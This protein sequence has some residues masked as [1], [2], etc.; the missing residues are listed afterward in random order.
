MTRQQIRHL[1]DLISSPRQRITSTSVF[2]LLAAV[3]ATLISLLFAFE[4]SELREDK[5]ASLQ[6]QIAERATSLE[7]TLAE[8]IDY[9]ARLNNELSYRLQHSP[10]T[11]DKIGFE[12]SPQDSVWSLRIADE[13]GWPVLLASKNDP[14]K[15]DAQASRELTALA[16]M[17]STLPL[18]DTGTGDFVWTYYISLHSFLLMYPVHDLTRLKD[19]VGIASLH[20][21]FAP[22]GFATRIVD[23]ALLD[24]V[25]ASTSAF[26]S[27]AYSDRAGRGLMTTV[28]QRLVG[29][30]GFRGVLCVDLPLDQLSPFTNWSDTGQL[31]LVNQRDQ[32]LGRNGDLAFVNEQPRMLEEILPHHGRLPSGTSEGNPPVIQLDDEGHIRITAPIHSAPFHLILL[33]DYSRIN[34]GVLSMMGRYPLAL[35][36]GLIILGVAGFVLLR[37]EHRLAERAQLFRAHFDLCPAGMALLDPTQTWLMVNAR[38]EEMLGYTAAELRRRRW[39][40][41]LIPEQQEE[42][43][44]NFRQLEVGRETR[45]TA[46]RRFVRADGKQ[47]PVE[48]E[49]SVIREASGSPDLYIVYLQDISR[50]QQL[51]SEHERTIAELQRSL[52]RL[53]TLQGL[54]PICVTCKKIRDDE[55]YW[56][57]VEEYIQSRSEAEF[58]HAICPDCMKKLYPDLLENG[59]TQDSEQA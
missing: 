14:R 57:A 3:F 18:R 54:F 5:L 48:V 45:L 17:A 53:R 51:E 13:S 15:L 30:E 47:L 29:E 28:K 27:G 56:H 9:L 6:A 32:L 7:S 34:L 11:Q 33:M 2:L 49:V 24:T 40:D 1:A 16:T 43:E 20:E 25:Q 58:S 42:C 37:L 59:D 26:W 10:F 55:G 23:H 22:G 38:C 4:F 44:E 46:T 50:K 36:L 8:R 12:W 21:A 52:E 41:M 19:E 39:C 35:L 31:L